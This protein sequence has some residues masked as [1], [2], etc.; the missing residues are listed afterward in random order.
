MDLDPEYLVFRHCAHE[1]LVKYPLTSTSCTAVAELFHL[2][3]FK[4]VLL[5]RGNTRPHQ[6]FP[7]I[8]S[9]VLKS[10]RDFLSEKP[11]L[12]QSWLEPLRLAL[13][14]ILS[15]IAQI[16]PPLHDRKTGET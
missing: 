13:S 6:P 14:E 9:V 15:Q 5:Q 16:I 2:E 3:I 12:G 8:K 1:T 11:A 10:G 4:S 7:I